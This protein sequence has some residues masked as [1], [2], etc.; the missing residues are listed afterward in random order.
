MTLRMYEKNQVANVDIYD[1]TNT[2]GWSDSPL[3]HTDIRRLRQGKVGAQVQ[4]WAFI[5][6]ELN[7]EVQFE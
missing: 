5:S 6:N 2:T 3:S 7:T 1:L 4:L